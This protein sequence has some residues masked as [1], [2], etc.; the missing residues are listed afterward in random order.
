MAMDDVFA[1]GSSSASMDAFAASSSSAA[2]TDPSHGWQKVVYP[3]RNRKHAAP[4][5]APP[6]AAPDL[7]KPSVFEGVDKRSQ[8][9]HRAIRAAR[10]AAAEADGSIAAWADD[11]DDGSDSDEA[12]KPQAEE[13]KKPKKPKVKKPK[14]TVADAAALIDAENLAAHLVD[15]SASYEN[16][17][18][19]QLMRFADYFGRAF[20][21]VSAA[22]FPWA[23]MFKESPMSKMV[24]VPLNHVPEPVCKTASDWINQ[25]SPEALGEFVLWCVDSI[26]SELS[27][28]PVGVKGSKKVVQQTPKAQVAIFVVLALTLRR[29]PDVLINISPKLAGNSKYLGQEKLP[30]I[31]WV[32][33]QAS[34]GDLV[35]GMF[36]WSHSLFPTLCAK[37][38]NPQSR[39]L[40]LQMLERF[41]STPNASKARGILL[42]GA[43]R[44]GERLVPAGTFDLFMRGAFPVPNARVKATERFEAAYPIM[45]E[46]ALAGPPGSKTVKQ[47]S[48]QLLPLALK[49]IQEKNVELT[50]EAADIFIWCLTQSPESYKQWDKLHPENIGASVAVLSKI[51]ADWKTLSPKL[52]SEALK[53]TLKSLKAKNEV[54]LEEAED[55]GKKASIK[56]ADKYCKVII[57]R[58]SRGATCLKG[59]LL[60]IALAAATGFALSPNLDLPSDLAT[61]QEHLAKVPEH[62]AMVPE[63]LSMVSARLQAMASEYLGSF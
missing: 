38:G 49:A 56:E 46:L 1:D 58:L 19:I 6:S 33:N 10:E 40:V 14:V 17:D 32:I 43:V 35:S 41:L 54:A 31:A 2:P 62:L 4:S 34:Q 8:E 28:Q 59:S 30:I 15:V 60:V 37:S 29:K 16:Q 24:E 11:T 39:D 18:G 44:K 13:V 9:R 63:H 61:V 22:Q 20:A 25:R 36:C 26:M 51:A 12:A 57:G 47:A 21:N 27:G 45:K 52:N 3:K 50:R 7:G 42:N 55:T 5:A 53:A 23:K 48:Q